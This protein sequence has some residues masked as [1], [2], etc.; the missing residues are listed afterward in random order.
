VV[1]NIKMDFDIIVEPEISHVWWNTGYGYMRV[2]VVVKAILKTEDR[3]Y[4]FATEKVEKAVYLSSDPAEIDQIIDAV[5]KAKERVYKQIQ[6]FIALRDRA[7][8]VL[9]QL[10]EVK[11]YL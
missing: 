2:V 11:E 9:S 8:K 10:G 5:E 6:A 3:Q 4:V 1:E 7:L